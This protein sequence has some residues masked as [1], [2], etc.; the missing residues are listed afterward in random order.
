MPVCSLMFW[1][2]SRL[3]LPRIPT[4]VSKVSKLSLRRLKNDTQLV[5]CH[6]SAVLN[7][8]MRTTRPMPAVAKGYARQKYFFKRIILLSSQGLTLSHSLLPGSH[9]LGI[10][11]PRSPL[12]WKDLDRS[13]L[14]QKPNYWHGWLSQYVRKYDAVF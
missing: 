12:S 10:G 11:S 1:R 8:G 2:E 13:P 7:R 14:G 6:M 9:E 4:E 5:M 3:P